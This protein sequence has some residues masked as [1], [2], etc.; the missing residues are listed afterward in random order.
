MTR[1]EPRGQRQQP[2][3]FRRHVRISYLRIPPSPSIVLKALWRKM[4]GSYSGLQST[5]HLSV[6]CFSLE[7]EAAR[8]WKQGA[9]GALRARPPRLSCLVA[10]MFN[11]L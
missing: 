10:D 2:G 8:A 9:R 6:G 5:A 7:I 11:N 4:K 1:P 3:S